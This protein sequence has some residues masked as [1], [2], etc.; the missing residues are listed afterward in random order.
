MEEAFLNGRGKQ[1]QLRKRKL[2]ALRSH[3]ER[4]CGNAGEK[5]RERKRSNEK[6][7]EEEIKKESKKERRGMKMWNRA[8]RRSL[9]SREGGTEKFFNRFTNL[10]FLD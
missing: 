6:D 9:N 2:M 7:K 10:H 3:G 5:R 1:K 8:D 4:G